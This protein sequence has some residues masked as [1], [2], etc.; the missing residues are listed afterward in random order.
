VK[1]FKNGYAHLT[2]NTVEKH[3]T[4]SSSIKDRECGPHLLTDTASQ[5]ASRSKYS[6]KDIWGHDR[7]EWGGGGEGGG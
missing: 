7:P 3:V 6:K 2:A 1:T 5:P 4:W